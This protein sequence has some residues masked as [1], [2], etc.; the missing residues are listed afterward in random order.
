[1]VMSVAGSRKAQLNGVEAISKFVNV[2][3]I[4]CRPQA[5]S[6]MSLRL[7]IVDNAKP[8]ID[9]VVTAIRVAKKCSSMIFCF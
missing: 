7:K 2:I 3:T 1:M 5:I 4:N 9:T 8:R 6:A